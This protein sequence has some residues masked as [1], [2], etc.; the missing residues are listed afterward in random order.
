MVRVGE[1]DNG[2]LL[3]VEGRREARVS[4]DTHKGHQKVIHLTPIYTQESGRGKWAGE[5]DLAAERPERWEREAESR[6]S[7][8]EEPVISADTCTASGWTQFFFSSVQLKLT[9]LTCEHQE[10][11]QPLFSA[12][13]C[14]MMTHSQACTG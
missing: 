12:Q 4:M 11:Q 14:F 3:Q 9:H 1:K 7:R 5:T 2:Q 10:E 8:R 6:I 13:L